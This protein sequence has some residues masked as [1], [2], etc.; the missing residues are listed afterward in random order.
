MFPQIPSHNP[1]DGE[2]IFLQRFHVFPQMQA[3]NY[4]CGIICFLQLKLDG[5][6]HKKSDPVPLHTQQPET[7]L[8]VTKPLTEA[9]VIRRVSGTVSDVSA[10]FSFTDSWNFVL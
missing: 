9:Q 5:N 10:T 4:D 2:D 1:K 3:R 7:R 6:M 8:N